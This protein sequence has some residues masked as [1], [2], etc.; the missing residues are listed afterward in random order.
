M[1]NI[2]EKN[3]HY[4]LLIYLPIYLV[5]FLFAEQVNTGD[6]FISYLP[7][8]DFIPFFPIFVVP[9][10]M[11]YPYM[12]VPA[13]IMLF[14]DVSAFKRFMYYLIITMSVS[15]IICLTVP[16]GQNL[17]V[18]ELGG[19]NLFTN[20]VSVIYSADTNTN[21]LPSMHVVGSIGI[22]CALYDS[23]LFKKV[24]IFMLILGVLICASTVFIKQHSI[25]DVIAGVLLAAV[26]I[27]LVY[28]LPRR[29]VKGRKK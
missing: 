10:V 5:S 23:K 1:K 19:G 8:D 13:I 18:T 3:G 25:L 21:V 4:L 24:K 15:L 26:T 7:I 20:L 17:R 27:L 14:R 29:K 2:L 6:Y 16:N 11:W 28:I 12:L 9:Y 22:I